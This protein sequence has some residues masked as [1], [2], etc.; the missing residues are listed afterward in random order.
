MVPP[1]DAAFSRNASVY[2]ITPDANMRPTMSVSGG[3]AGHLHQ[4]SRQQAFS[5]NFAVVYDMESV[6]ACWF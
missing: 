3:K 4:T 2:R 6:D 5:W 1:K